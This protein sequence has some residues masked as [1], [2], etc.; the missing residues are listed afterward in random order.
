ML[1]L[2]RSHLFPSVSDDRA[3]IIIPGDPALI[4]SHSN[5]AEQCSAIQKQLGS[6]RIRGRLCNRY[7]ITELSRI[8]RCFSCYHLATLHRRTI[9]IQ[10]TKK[11]KLNFISMTLTPGQLSFPRM[12]T[13][14]IHLLFEQPPSATLQ[15]WSVG[16]TRR[17]RWHSMS[18]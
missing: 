14:R 12:L 8:C 1:T 17:G 5:F 4:I 3:A 6:L 7:N 2:N 9:K 13:S 18:K 11:M 10:H 16:R 15:L